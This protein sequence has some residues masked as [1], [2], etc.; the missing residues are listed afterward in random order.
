MH[1]NKQSRVH[2]MM[3]SSGGS[4]PVRP[5]AMG[6]GVVKGRQVS[7]SSNTSI[8]VSKRDD[9]ANLHERNTSTWPRTRSPL[10]ASARLALFPAAVQRFSPPRGSLRPALRRPGRRA[11]PCRPP[12]TAAAAN[13]GRP[14]VACGTLNGVP[15]ARPRAGTAGPASKRSPRSDKDGATTPTNENDATTFIVVEHRTTGGSRPSRSCES[16]GRS[17]ASGPTGR[18]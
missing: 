14:H 18:G 6:M 15:E 5:T 2:D 1:A 17:S 11:R 12:R 10:R 9:G 8:T 13:Q 3:N 16:R 7:E 4:I